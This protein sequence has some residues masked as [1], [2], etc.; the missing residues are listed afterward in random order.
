V[1]ELVLFTLN[2]VIASFSV[3]WEE[4]TKDDEKSV[5][6]INNGTRTTVSIAKTALCF[7]IDCMIIPS[8]PTTRRAVPAIRVKKK[9][10]LSLDQPRY[11]SPSNICT[12]RRLADH[13]CS[14]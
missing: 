3:C 9:K 10:E 2:L 6:K 7:L 1:S 14:Q 5:I 13:V 11:E 4:R 12:V 8:T